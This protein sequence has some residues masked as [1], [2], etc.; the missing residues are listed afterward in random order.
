MGV[1][2]KAE[3]KGLCCV[4]RPQLAPY[5]LMCSC[6]MFSVTLRLIMNYI[7]SAS[8]SEARAVSV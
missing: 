3:F 7:T 4:I 2:M 5:T 1:E 8:P 6:S